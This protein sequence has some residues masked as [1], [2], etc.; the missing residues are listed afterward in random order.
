MESG[1][2]MN[3]III[4]IYLL[5]GFVMAMV[6]IIVMFHFDVLTGML[7]ILVGIYAMI[8]ATNRVQYE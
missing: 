8:R 6:G 3:D 2:N 4:L 7:I 5:T 1:Q